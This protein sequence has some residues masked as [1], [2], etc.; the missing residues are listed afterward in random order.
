MKDKTVKLLTFVTIVAMFLILSFT[1]WSIAC[2]MFTAGSIALKIAI[3]VV[4]YVVIGGIFAIIV[5]SIVGI[6]LRLKYMEAKH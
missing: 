2:A 4:L 6:Y 5:G 1:S 3:S